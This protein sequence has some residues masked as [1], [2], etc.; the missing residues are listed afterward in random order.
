VARIAYISSDVV[1]SV[2]PALGH[3]SEFSKLLHT[4]A[5][6]RTPGIIAKAPE[7]GIIQIPLLQILKSFRYKHFDTMLTLFSLLSNLFVLANSPP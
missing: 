6:D 4:L 2:Q 7:V 1:L 5:K 3:N